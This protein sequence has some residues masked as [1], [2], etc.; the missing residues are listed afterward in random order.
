MKK[1]TRFLFVFVAMLLVA[2]LTLAA[3]NPSHTEPP[4]HVCRHLCGTCDKCTDKN[5]SDPECADK[6]KGHGS[7]NDDGN[8]DD[9]GDDDEHECESKCETCND[10]LNAA[11]EEEAC[12]NKCPK[13]HEVGG[14]DDK[15]IAPDI[16]EAF[17]GAIYH[18]GASGTVGEMVLF[19]NGSGSLTLANTRS[20]GYT[21]E[22]VNTAITYTLIDG[23]FTI[24]T[25]PDSK[26]KV[27]AVGKVEGRTVSVTVTNGLNDNETS[28]E[29]KSTLSKITVKN[30]YGNNETNTFYYPQGYA[31]DMSATLVGYKLDY[32]LVNGV[33][34][35]ESWLKTFAVTGED[36]TLQY[37]WTQDVQKGDYTVVYKPGEGTG[38]DYTDY[39]TTNAYKV[40]SIYAMTSPEDEQEEP[41][42]VMNFQAPQGKYF[43]GWLIEGTETVV[44]NN[45]NI[46]LTSAVTT[47]VAQWKSNI[48]VTLTGLHWSGVESNLL[49]VGW[50]GTYAEGLTNT[51]TPS[52]NF[53]LP[54]ETAQWNAVAHVSRSGF[55]LLGWYCAEHD[56]I[57]AP[58]ASHALSN[59]I[60][61]E[62]KWQQDT[63]TSTFDG[64]YVATTALDLTSWAQGIYVRA[65]LSGR[66]LTLYTADGE[67]Y[68]VDNLSISGNTA[69]GTLTFFTFTLKL[70]GDTLTISVKRGGL[71]TVHEGTFTRQS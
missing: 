15:P 60:T 64:T 6:C 53:S 50:Q 33:P 65:V 3:C 24:W 55:I 41:T 12:K 16:T 63:G 28:Y 68:V 46:T 17:N 57:H 42:Y 61:F 52:S 45:A 23:V 10:C 25:A 14:G 69:T 71:A 18:N 11:C 48:T 38:T 29:F 5:C 67:T 4:G 37:A 22:F 27:P 7:L 43:A 56:E 32:V 31:A 44:G 1:F 2:S 13:N 19:A 8:N 36:V 9:G 21:G 70:E 51:F 26:I 58:G 49:T 47:L 39:A 40:L 30:M 35:T 34:K 59:D 20:S 62:A 66:K 54:G